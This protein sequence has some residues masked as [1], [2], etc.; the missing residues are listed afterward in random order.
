MGNVNITEEQAKTLKLFSYYAQS[1]GKKEVNKSIYTV[2]CVLDWKDDG[3]VYA[4]ARL[5]S[6]DAIDTVINEIIEENDLLTKSVTDCDNKGTLIISIDCVNRNLSIDAYETV[7][8]VRPST[9]ILSLAELEEEDESLTNIFNYMK[10]AGYTR[11][12]VVFGGGGGDGNIEP[13]ILYDDQISER[14]PNK[15][16]NFF[17]EWLSNYYYG[18]QN[19]EGSQG[20]FIFH[21]DT[22]I[23]ELDFE[24]N[25]FDDNSLGQVFYTDF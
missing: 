12:E 22:D 13:F 4:G 7:I 14:L 16:E 11:G 15:V 9:D 19:E 24:E 2:D 3:W 5:E 25:H 1:Y 23:L 20:S 17:Y 6:Y 8:D 18:W 21:S 10:S